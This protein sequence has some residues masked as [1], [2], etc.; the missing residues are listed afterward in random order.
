ML[1][2]AASALIA[3]AVTYDKDKQAPAVRFTFS[4]ML[5][6]HML[7]RLDKASLTTL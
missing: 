5:Q 7:F 6:A 4:I 3:I 1:M 2:F